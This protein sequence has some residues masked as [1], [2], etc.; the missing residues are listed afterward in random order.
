MFP[1]T[2]IL[3]MDGENNKTRWVAVVTMDSAKLLNIALD[4]LVYKV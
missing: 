3:S 4:I 1:L 2:T